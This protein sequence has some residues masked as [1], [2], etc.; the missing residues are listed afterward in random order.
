MFSA[1]LYKLFRSPLT[2]FAIVG[3]VALCWTHVLL[4]HAPFSGDVV[5]HVQLFL[6]LDAYRK[7]VPVF[8]ALPFTANFADEWKSGVTGYCITRSGVKKYSAA[9]VLFCAVSSLVTV[10]GGMMLFVW[11]YSFFIPLYDEYENP[12]TNLFGQLLIGG[13]GMIFIMLRIFVFA[14]S[15]SMWAVMGLLMSAFMPNKY[16]AIAAPFV[17]SYIVE[18]IT[19]QFPP[20]LNLWYLSLC[21]TE[22]SNDL[23]GFLYTVGIFAAISAA[24]GVLF[25]MIVRKR[26]RNEIT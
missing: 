19:L 10:F 8:G 4:Y 18:R 3:T 24:C 23:I 26:V 16:V 17:A 14:C 21:A 9:N 22:W 15:C 13:H 1:Y 11:M 2:Y 12:Y 20:K 5:Y 25:Y 7:V 6:D